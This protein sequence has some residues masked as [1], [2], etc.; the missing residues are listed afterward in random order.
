MTVVHVLEPF[1][2]GVTTAVESITKQLPALKHIVVHGSRMWVDDIERVKGRF[3]PGVEFIPWTA[4][5]REI[6][7]VKDLRALAQLRRILKPFQKTDTVI[8][9]HSSKAGF[10]GRLAC[11]LLGIDRVIYT[12]HCGAFVRTDISA[13]KRSLFRLLEKTGGSFGGTVVGCCKSEAELYRPLSPK[14]RPPRWV[15]NGV[16]LVDSIDTPLQKNGGRALVSFSGI[17][18]PQKD[19]ELF[20]R[21]ALKN[22]EISFCWIG[23][24]P[25]K[26]RL[27][28]PNI[29]IS[30]WLGKAEVAQRLAQTGIYLSTAAWE[31]LPFGV[32]EAM[33][34]GCAL[35]L[36][37]I[38]G[39][40]DL[41]IPGENGYLFSNEYDAAKLLR[42]MQ[43]DKEKILMMGKKSREL[44]E[45]NYSGEQMGRNYGGLYAALIA[46]GKI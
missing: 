46:G 36:R 1:A 21:I 40:R 2:S 41:V 19:P 39:N 12:P 29:T 22:P 13:F 6:S 15:N 5:G 14:N 37:D 38:P 24:G 17:A 10:L 31:G 27:S 26:D 7:P 20:N 18:G 28:A 11:R 30:G 35:L 45:T 25:L 34:A 16:E 4:A 9:L 3:P 44:V 8:H 33:N 43:I 23:D 32:L 42:E